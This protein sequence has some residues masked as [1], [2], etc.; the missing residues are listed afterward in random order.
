MREVYRTTDT[1]RNRDVA[2]KVL[3]PAF[4]EDAARMTRFE[5][6]AQMPASLNH[7][8]VAAIHGIEQGA[9]V[10]ELLEAE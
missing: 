1:K 10:M 8:N 5:R 7:P 6:A 4:A 2:L 9:I 3:R